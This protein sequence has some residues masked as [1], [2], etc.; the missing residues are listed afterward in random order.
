MNILHYYKKLDDVIVLLVAGGD[1][2]NQNKTIKKAGE[3]LKDYL[4]RK[5]K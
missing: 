2:S 5:D 3:Y 1:K 4:E